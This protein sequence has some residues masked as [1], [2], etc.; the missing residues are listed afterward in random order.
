[1]RPVPCLIILASL[2]SLPVITGAAQPEPVYPSLEA[3]LLREP[4]QVV[5]EAENLYQIALASQSNSEQISALHLLALAYQ[6]LEDDAE[7]SRVADE[8]ARLAEMEANNGY[9]S[10]FKHFKAIILEKQGDLMGAL[11]ALDE[12]ISLAGKTGNE[13]LVAQH[14]SGRGRF[15]LYRENFDL[16]L[17]DFLFAHEIYERYG[18]R[19]NLGQSYNDLAVFYESTGEYQKAVEYHLK[20]ASYGNQADLYDTVITHLNLGSA[21]TGMGDYGKAENELAEARTLAAQIQDE[22]SLATAAFWLGTIR[23]E[24]HKY[25][26]ATTYFTEALNFFNDNP[27]AMMQFNCHI[28]LAYNSIPLFDY[29]AAQQHLAEAETLFNKLQTPVLR[30]DL[31][32]ARA[33]F[34]RAM[35]DYQRTSEILTEQIELDNLLYNVKK[36]QSLERMKLRFHTA[37]KEDENT[38]LQ[39]K[40]EVQELQIR[41]NKE[42]QRYQMLAIALVVALLLL[43]Y[44]AYLKQKKLKQK[45]ATLALTD[46]LTGLP[47]RR[48][49]LEIAEQELLRAN[50]YDLPLSLVIIDLDYFKQVNDRHGHD[51]GD[52]VLQQFTVICMDIIRKHDSLGRMGGEEW[53]GIFPHTRPEELILIL[54]RIRKG[55]ANARISG[56]SSV[57]QLTFSAG[58]SVVTPGDDDLDT[59]LKRADRAMYRAKADGRDRVLLSTSLPP[60]TLSQ[61]IES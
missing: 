52:R 15:H 37:Q 53:L 33:A 3:R 48:H 17:E 54:K 60:D 23:S 25:A 44:L 58:I 55:Y 39:Q 57:T 40:N 24:Q 50:R 8:G 20:A 7:L 16:A 27:D 43:T 2:L 36:E 61:A 28:E 1:M 9:L 35:G 49:I 13:Q 29:A 42:E 6:T 51:V 59:V 4:R 38:I 30:L 22:S 12:A 41:R 10:E 14:I 21:Y 47:N 45:M 56:V 31:L 46:E 11:E 26:E 19:D 34:Y 18:D 5:S 32:M